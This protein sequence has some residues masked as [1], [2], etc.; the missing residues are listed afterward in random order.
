MHPISDDIK[1][2]SYDFKNL[3]RCRQVRT[4]LY[5]KH[6]VRQNKYITKQLLV[7]SLFS[8]SLFIRIKCDQIC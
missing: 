6:L 5:P 2:S 7:E 3:C 8:L 4:V 1:I